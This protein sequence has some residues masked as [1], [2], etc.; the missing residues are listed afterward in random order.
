MKSRAW[1]RTSFL[2]ILFFVG[3][4]ASASSLASES[5]ENLFPH[6]GVG[7][8]RISPD[9]K[10]IVALASR[11][12]RS[13]VLVQRVGD[14]RSSSALATKDYVSNVTWVGGSTIIVEL[15]T[16]VGRRFQLI[17]FSYSYGEVVQKVSFIDASGWLIDPRP[18]VDDEVIWAFNYRDRAS[19][20]R[21]SLEELENFGDKRT[22]RGR[23]VLPGESLAS[24]KGSANRWVVDRDGEPRAIRRVDAEGYTI[25]V[26][27]K[28]GGGFREI[29]RYDFN[30]NENGLTPVA[31]AP[32]DR[33]LIVIAYNGKNTRGVYL[34]DPKTGEFGEALFV[35]PDVDVKGVRIDFT[36]HEIFS[37]AFEAGGEDR[38]HYLA[39]YGDEILSGLE[40]SFARE[41]LQ[42][43]SISADRGLFVFRV[44]DATNPGAY[45]IRDV[46]R[47]Q[48]TLLAQQGSNINRDALSPVTNFVVESQ[49][50]TEIEAFLALPK[51]K[52]GR[53]APLI[54]MPH[55]GPINVRDNRSYDSFVQYF[56]SWGFA[57]LQPNYRGSRGYGLDFMKSGKKQW[58]RGIEDD[59]D[60]TVDYAASIP[61]VDGSRICIVGG[62]YGGFAA[63][64]SIV[65]H[66]ERYACAI[67]WNGVS[68]I[69]LLYDSSDIADS[70]IA[71]EFYEEFVGDLE[72]ER[73]KLIDASPAY[74]VERI[75]TPVYFIF[76]TEDRRV[77]PDHSHRMMLMLDL[78]DKEFESLEVKGMAHGPSRREGIIIARAMRRYVSKYLEPAQPYEPDPTTEA[79][80]SID[81]IE[82]PRVEF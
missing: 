80:E 56:A 23:F 75:E 59:I 17:R 22:S 57:V 53:S 31:I 47:S 70:E 13:G 2:L 8:V 51:S 37:A 73:E 27:R 29:H 66:K 9:G 71:L 54:V 55:G 43:I 20:H 36:S 14:G 5:A 67:S 41:S 60:A 35:R 61:E 44:S 38:Y 12:L 40:D 77:D 62:S 46:A 1:N 26:P 30:D 7:N 21:V 49:D 74:H 72:T 11:G 52:R 10:W 4:L 76:G 34:F 45:Y 16:S 42:A 25:L 48:T 64:A 19:L 32:D 58:A 3:W 63:L 65:R 39:S 15:H 78:Y 50:G 69:P 24:I 79:E 33:N 82:A 6:T 68:D 18:L 81:F 28:M